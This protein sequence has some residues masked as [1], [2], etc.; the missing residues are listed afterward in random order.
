MQYFGKNRIY[1]IIIAILIVLIGGLYF[2]VLFP[3]RHMPE[4]ISAYHH[5]QFFEYAAFIEKSVNEAQNKKKIDLDKVFG[6]IVPHHL[7]TTIPLLAEFYGSLKNMRDVKTFIILGP[8]HVDSAR[9]D[10]STSK[11]NFITPFGQLKPNLEFIEQL[12][13][14]GFV[15]VDEAPFDKEISIDSQLLLINNLFP[16]SKIV[17][18]V[19][20]SSIT[21]ETARTF[22]KMLATL[23]DENTFIVASVD[24]SHY[25][26]Q[27]QAGPIDQLSASVLGAINSRFGGL[28]EAD[29]PQA[30]TAFISA[31]ETMGA[32]HHAD[33]KILNT[34][35]FSNNR[36]YTTGYVSG[37]W[38]IKS[39]N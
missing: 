29:S 2:L 33:L 20:R 36:D 27:K 28:V 3:Q 17:P 1:F 4:I 14:S 39:K 15:V 25:L 13:K 10:I 22:G 8:D 31:V 21:N 24:F 32:N 5:S 12:E 18:L 11:A 23:L 35:D 26:S 9:G 7:P 16:D 37:F 19:F 34:A 30:L 6:G 38:G